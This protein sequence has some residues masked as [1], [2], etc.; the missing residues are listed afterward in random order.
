MTKNNFKI[1]FRILLKAYFTVEGSRERYSERLQENRSS[2]VLGL[3]GKSL[4]HT[5]AKLVLGTTGDVF[6]VSWKKTSTS[7]SGG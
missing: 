2:R 6:Q 3:L 4:A 7:A 5:G 1:C